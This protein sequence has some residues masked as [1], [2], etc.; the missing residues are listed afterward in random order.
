MADR[1]NTNQ[2]PLILPAAWL[3]LVAACC[4]A[5]FDV[6]GAPSA[7]PVRASEDGVWQ[8]ALNTPPGQTRRPPWLP[9]G[10]GREFKLN[11]GMLRSLLAR[12]PREFPPEARRDAPVVTLPMPDG[13]F[14]RFHVVE[15][16]IME[17]ELAAKFPELKTYSGQGLDEPTA[18]VRFDTSPTGLHALV[19]SARGPVFVDPMTETDSD[20]YASVR[21]EDLPSEWEGLRCDTQPGNPAPAVDLAAFASAAVNPA[22]VLRTYRLALAARGE[23]TQFHGGTVAG[24]LAAIVTSVNRVNSIYERDLAI[25]MVLVANEDRIIYLDPLTDPYPNLNNS[26]SV[27]D[28]QANLDAVIGSANYDVGHVVNQRILPGGIAWVGSACD[29]LNKAK[30]STSVHYPAGPAFEVDYFGHELGHQFGAGH[31][32]NGTNHFCTLDQYWPL[33]AFEP[34][35]GSTIMSYVASCGS[36]DLQPIGS[37]FFHSGSYA[38]ITSYITSGTGASCPL[39]VITG[40]RAPTVSAGPNYTIPKGTPFT[41]TAMGSDPD[42][43]TLTYSWEEHDLGPPQPLTGPGSADNGSSPLFRTFDP[44]TNASRTFPKLEALLSHTPSHGETISV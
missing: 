28:N 16:P 20:L 42:G 11:H 21:R 26:T 7:T 23:Y 41:L 1:M 32:Y 8:A 19:V 35:S 31:T 10:K 15:S 6:A 33:A 34:G 17:P 25:R 9:P 13:S 2:T 5:P 37:P 44:T 18:T 14:A 4:F 29:P 12:A 39:P 24:A 3:S 40:N 43:D 30:G 22:V 36:D 38:E 27:D